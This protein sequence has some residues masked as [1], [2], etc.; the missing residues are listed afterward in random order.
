MKGTTFVLQGDKLELLENG[1]FTWTVATVT[2]QDGKDYT[3]KESAALFTVKIADL[4]SATI[5]T[6][7]LLG[8]E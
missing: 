5:D 8:T 2:E 1:D 6:S 4:E 7:D 3:G